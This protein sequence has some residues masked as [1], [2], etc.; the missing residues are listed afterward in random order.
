MPSSSN[1]RRD[2]GL[3]EIKLPKP[4]ICL[5]LSRLPVLMLVNSNMLR[6]LLSIT[7]NSSRLLPRHKTLHTRLD[8]LDLNSSKPH[9]RALK[10]YWERVS[11]SSKCSS[12]K[13][14]KATI[15]G[16]PIRLILISSFRPILARLALL[17]AS[18]EQLRL[19]PVVLALVIHNSRGQAV[20]LG[21]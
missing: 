7:N 18:A 19:I 5:M 20:A 15:S 10:L 4:K 8:S 11:C 9:C 1:R 16:L 21:Q 17:A 14:T 3:Q 13:S 6:L 2:L 12:S